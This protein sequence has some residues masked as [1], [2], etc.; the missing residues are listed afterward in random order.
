M[1][2]IFE[3]VLDGVGV[4]LDYF[5]FH[6]AY[7]VAFSFEDAAKPPG[8]GEVRL[9]HFPEVAGIGVLIDAGD[10]LVTVLVGDVLF[11]FHPLIE[12][13]ERQRLV[14]A[15]GMA[16]QGNGREDG[17]VKHGVPDFFAQFVQVP[18]VRHCNVDRFAE[19]KEHF[20]PGL[21]KGV[22]FEGA[23]VFGTVALRHA[24]LFL[25]LHQLREDF[26]LRDALVCDAHGKNGHLP[27]FVDGSFGHAEDAVGEL[28]DFAVV[29]AP[30]LGVYEDSFRFLEDLFGKVIVESLKVDDVLFLP[31]IL[32]LYAFAV[33]ADA[34][35][36][37]EHSFEVA[38]EKV[39]SRDGAGVVVELF[40]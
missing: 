34:L 33:K 31:E 27:V 9:G 20:A 23:E 36:F 13:G 30:G 14:F 39:L 6:Y 32:F 29:G 22:E 26:V 35:D 3:H 25:D 5:G 40:Q 17:L 2:L 8:H 37:R 4:V 18:E 12:L 19:R 15:E 24:F 1:T 16:D 11:P 7:R 28:S 21:E 10:H 38:V